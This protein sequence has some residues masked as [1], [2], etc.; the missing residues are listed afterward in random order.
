MND[1]ISNSPAPE[2]CPAPICSPSTIAPE[3]YAWW[4]S[5]VKPVYFAMNKKGIKEL[6]IVRTE[7]HKVRFE[8]IPEDF[9]AEAGRIDRTVNNGGPMSEKQPGLRTISE[10]NTEA[11]QSATEK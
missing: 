10:E 5:L 6:H 3:A 4:R 9:Q 2:G 1:P 7:G 8:L 11:W